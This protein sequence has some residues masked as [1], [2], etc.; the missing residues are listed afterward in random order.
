MARRLVKETFDPSKKVVVRRPFTGGGR[1][2]RPGDEFVWAHM[3]VTQR[4]VRQ[5]YD[6]GY[7]YHINGYGDRHSMVKSSTAGSNFSPSAAFPPPAQEVGG[8]SENGSAVE[9]TQD[10]LSDLKMSDLREIA[11]SEGA[12]IK[13]SKVDQR[14]AIRENRNST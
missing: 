3:A 6:A 4:R 12:E 10:D 1:H 9:D 8:S 2:Y 7:L 13:V 11:K 5:L 14:A